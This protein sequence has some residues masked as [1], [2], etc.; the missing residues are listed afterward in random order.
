M[1]VKTYSASEE[2]LILSGMVLHEGVLGRLYRHLQGEPRPFRSLWCNRLLEW[3]FRHWREYHQPPKG[4]IFSYFTEWAEA[5]PD[6]A[7]VELMEQF[8]ETLK[9]QVPEE[10]NEE[11][12]IDTAARHFKQVALERLSE[13]I[14]N[15]LERNQISEAE[16]QVSSFKRMDL[17]AHDWKDPFDPEL[18][19]RALHHEQEED[20]VALPGALGEFFSQRL[21]R[22]DFLAFAGPDKRG[23]S[24][25]LME[26]VYRALRSRRKVLYYVLGDMSDLEVEERFV[27]RICRRPIRAR[28]IRWPK[29]IMPQGKERTVQGEDRHFSERITWKEVC[30]EMTRFMES[31]GAKNSRL[32]LRCE[33]GYLL[34]ASDIEYHIREFTREGWIPDVIVIDYADLLRPEPETSRQE[35][36]HQVNQTWLTLRRIALELHCLVITATQTDA[37]AYSAHLIGMGN[38]SEDKRK[39][40]HVT[41][42]VG[43]NQTDAEKQQGLYRLNWI[44]SRRGGFVRHQV[45]YTAGELAVSSPCLISS[46]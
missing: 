26:M 21:R 16:M 7:T 32:K 45:L 29:R 34:A 27:A 12:V 6:R 17:A 28:H 10:I 18:A 5:A 4:T 31:I 23:K 39:N 36:R 1:K 13:T 46:W 24:F 14:Q 8:L 19:Q 25:W 9:E 43:I 35:V 3:C 44:V 15:H 2:Y 38:F 37:M 20:L 41:G 33:G 42:M 40:A 22:T 11:F 30:E